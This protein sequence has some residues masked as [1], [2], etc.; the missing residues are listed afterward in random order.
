MDYQSRPVN[1][2]ARGMQK[3]TAAEKAA[4][5]LIFEEEDRQLSDDEAH[6]KSPKVRPCWQRSSEMSALLR[7]DPHPARVCVV[8]ERVYSAR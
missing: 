8:F 7:K 5:E 3:V 2:P 1:V 6:G 4:F